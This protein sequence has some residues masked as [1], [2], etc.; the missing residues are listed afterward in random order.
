MAFDAAPVTNDFLLSARTAS[1]GQNRILLISMP[2]EAVRSGCNDAAVAPVFSGGEVR[3][4][5]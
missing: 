3:Q 2:L 5:E 4:T 1:E